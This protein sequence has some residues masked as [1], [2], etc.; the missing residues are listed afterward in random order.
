MR[1]SA[2]L[3]LVKRGYPLTRRDTTA[4]A[5]S[6]QKH[7]LSANPDTC[8]MQSSALCHGQPFQKADHMTSVPTRY[9]PIAKSFHWITA[10][11]IFAIIPLG[12]IA[13]ELPYDTSAQLAQKAFLFSIHKTL[14]VTVFFVALLR[15]IWALTHAKPAPLHPER[16]AETFAAETVHWLLYGSLVIAPLTGWIHHAATVGFA[17]IWWPFGQDLPFVPKDIGLANL[18][19]SLHWVLTKVMAAAIVLHV[20]GAL[21]HQF[22]DKDTT[23]SRMW[24]SSKPSPEV[25]AHRAPAAAPFAALAV[26]VLASGA[27]IAMNTAS[28]DGP[29]VPT[30][31]AV[32]S[33]WQVQSGEIAITVLQF[34]SDVAGS[35]ADWTADISFDEN[36]APNHGE[37]NVTIAIGSVSIGSVTQQALGAEYFDAAVFPT[38]TFA[39]PITSTDAGYVVD[40]TLTIKDA[41]IPITLPFDLTLDGDTAMMSATVELDRR[42]FGIGDNGDD[43]QLGFIVPVAINLTATRS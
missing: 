4:C 16:K 2:P 18:F 19:G 34:G 14:G 27:A 28:E 25:P 29:A 33:E 12:V 3:L 7:S 30:L 11:L 26:F 36:A 21:K 10:L 15:I 40:G 35:F 13:H 5:H 23:L 6:A 39:G 24:F 17:P 8:T 41:S 1:A 9:D 37:V 32:A 20:A 22:I 38:A 43:A 42:D 31:D